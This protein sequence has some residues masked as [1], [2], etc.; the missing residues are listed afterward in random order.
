MKAIKIIFTTIFILVVCHSCG[1]DDDAPPTLMDLS[2]YVFDSETGDSIR[3]VS[4]SMSA[5]NIP[6]RTINPSSS[7]DFGKYIFRSLETGDYKLYAEKTGY[8]PN[9]IPVEILPNKINETSISIT[10]IHN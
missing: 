7:D 9:E 4:L 3:G 5:L 10:E 1:N 8:I 2:V 6:G